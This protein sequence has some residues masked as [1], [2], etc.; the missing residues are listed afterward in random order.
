MYFFA[1]IGIGWTI[2]FLVCAAFL[3]WLIVTYI[4]IRLNYKPLFDWW[5]NNGGNKYNDKLNLFTL[6]TANYSS[7]MY[8]ISKSMSTPLNQLEVPQ[9]RFILGQLL[10]YLTYV[11]DETQYGLLTPKSLCETVLLSSSDNDASFN[12]WLTNSYPH[13]FPAGTKFSESTALEYEQAPHDP[14]KDTQ[15]ENKL[16]FDYKRKTNGVYPS[17]S[18]QG[19]WIG[20]I[21]EW[22]G[23]GWVIESDST[24]DNILNPQYIGEDQKS[25][26]NNWFNNT[27]EGR[28]DNFL[29]RMGMYPDAALVLYFCDNRYS[30]K[31]MKIDSQSFS[32]LLG[33][34]GGVN[35]G[36][37]VGF[38]NGLT[39]YNL[40]Q[41]V[42]LLRSK[43]DIKEPP[44]PPPCKKSDTSAG[45]AAGLGTGLGIAG[46]GAMAFPVP[47]VGPFLALGCLAAG[48][49]AGYQSGTAA[50]K[51]TC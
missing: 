40:N 30:I 11:I 18:D 15:N 13:N 28:P 8:Y 37:W 2:V 12:Y 20:L 31:G 39:G 33:G 16:W 46:I 19:G 38:L 1:K 6:A 41:Y 32:F 47:V 5:V 10:P 14:P 3:I 29:A 26:Y 7:L 43:T 45:V 23:D 25:S 17:L 22:L 51:G 27:A 4:T 35:A 44:V 34:A 50:A 24:N 9:I 49:F 42:T 48:I 36:G 21:L